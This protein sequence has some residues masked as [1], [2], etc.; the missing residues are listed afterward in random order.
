MGRADPRR[1]RRAARPILR[2]A[3]RARDPRAV[4]A[5]GRDAQQHTLEEEVSR[6]IRAQPGAGGRVRESA[7]SDLRSMRARRPGPADLPQSPDHIE[8]ARR[9]WVVSGGRSRS[10]ARKQRPACREAEGGR[11]PIPANADPARRTAKRFWCRWRAAGSGGGVRVGRGVGRTEGEGC[12]YPW[13]VRGCRGFRRVGRG[14]REA[15]AKASFRGLRAVKSVI[16]TD[17]SSSATFGLDGV[18]GAQ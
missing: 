6:P 14:S 7:P 17:I 3:A 5:T 9:R 16:R 2:S 8:N 15:G 18:L 12:A 1:P 11:E 10:A 13:R 4:Q